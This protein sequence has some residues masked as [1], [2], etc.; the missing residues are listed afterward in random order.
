MQACNFTER[1]ILIVFSAIR[2]HTSFEKAMQ[3]KATQASVSCPS[4]NTPLDTMQYHHKK[5]CLTRTAHYEL[6]QSINCAH[7]CLSEKKITYEHTKAYIRNFSDKWVLLSCIFRSF[8][9]SKSP[10]K[11]HGRKP[12]LLIF[13]LRKS[14]ACSYLLKSISV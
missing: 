13:L 2:A 10:G 7:L 1:K 4:F 14:R 11:L 6:R 8:D 9:L 5:T 3:F 12:Y